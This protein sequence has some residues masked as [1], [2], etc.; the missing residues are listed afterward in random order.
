METPQPNSKKAETYAAKIFDLLNSDD[1]SHI[2]IFERAQ[3]IIDGV[4][5]PTD[6]AIKRG[7]F[8]QDLM[9]AVSKYLAKEKT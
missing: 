8:S 5:F 7:R 2:K 1:K 9:A 6:D 3:K 4:G